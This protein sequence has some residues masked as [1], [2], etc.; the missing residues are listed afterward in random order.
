MLVP[1]LAIAFSKP[2]TMAGAGSFAAWIGV[3]K[4]EY[5]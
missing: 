4:T 5:S 1:A 3:T 2:W